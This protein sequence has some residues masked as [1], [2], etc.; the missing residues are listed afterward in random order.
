M[1]THDK[2]IKEVKEAVSLPARTEKAM[3][4]ESP[5]DLKVLE[6]RDRLQRKDEVKK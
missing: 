5:S 4:D 3:L 6:R 1:K 2:F